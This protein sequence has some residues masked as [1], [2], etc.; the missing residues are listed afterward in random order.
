MTDR[1]VIESALTLI[2]DNLMIAYDKRISHC[3]PL[4][5]AQLSAGYRQGVIDALRMLDQI[6]QE[7]QTVRPVPDET[8]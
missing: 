4:V 1:A 7:R 2:S 8:A 5:K 3:K 6:N